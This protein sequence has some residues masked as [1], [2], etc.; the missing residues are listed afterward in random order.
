MIILKLIWL[1]ILGINLHYLKDFKRVIINLACKCFDVSHTAENIFKE[2]EETI[3]SWNLQNKVSLVVRD[4]AAN[5]VAAFKNRYES[6]GC[7][8]HTLQ[9]VIKDHILGLASVETLIR[10]F[11]TLCSHASR[12][13]AF[14][15]ELYRQQKIQMGLD[16]P[17]R[18]MNDV[19]TRWD[20][21]YYMLER[22]LFLK[23]ALI[24]TLANY[25]DLGIEFSNNEWIL[26]KK[27]VKILK[28]FQTATKMLS[29]ADATISQVIPIVTT[30]M[31]ELE[32]NGC[33][34][35]V[36]TTKRSLLDGMN[37]RFKGIEFRE[38]CA[39][40]TVLDTRYKGYVF[41]DKTA[42]EL[43]R[44]GLITKLENA[45]AKD[46]ENNSENLPE[47][48]ENDGSDQDQFYA[49]MNK[50]IKQSQ[51]QVDSQ[52]V[53]NI[54]KVLD[55]YLNS[56]IQENNTEFWQE[57]AK[58]RNVVKQE[59]AKLAD[60]YLTGPPGSVCIER[61]FSTT[62]DILT[63]ERNNLNPDTVE[64]ILFCRFNLAAIK[65]QY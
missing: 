23:P 50:I 65:Y 30:I 38:K 61:C 7:M 54:N 24:S 62:G 39:Y 58:S 17:Y 22:G 2:V 20:A 12:S 10:K 53:T 35:G 31:K 13:N 52:D 21:S 49:T 3:Q 51:S 57:M 11:Q 8:N 1:S 9:L 26:L 19:A 63:Q 41:R 59:L 45:I 56:P 6:F 18:L 42:L 4:N 34:F 55:E 37:E 60:Y 64:K 33:D 43:V 29:K 46:T 36:K 28:P 5:M 27:V 40:A 44:G 32:V 15:N 16:K 47:M 25:P 48:A 14:Y